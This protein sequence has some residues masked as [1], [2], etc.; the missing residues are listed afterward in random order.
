MI[1][2]VKRYGALIG[3]F[4]L[5]LVFAGLYVLGFRSGAE[6]WKDRAKTQKARADA[7]KQEQ[8]NAKE[9][10]EIA[11]E[12]EHEQIKQSDEDIEDDGYTSTLDGDINNYP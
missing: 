2:T 8:K 1:P 9:A 7:I 11:T 10:E 3:A 12:Y 4:F 5:I 6:K